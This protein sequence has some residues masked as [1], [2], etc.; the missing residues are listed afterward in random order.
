[1]QKS[2]CDMFLQTLF[3]GQDFNIF[4]RW[5]DAW[6]DGALCVRR[7]PLIDH[8]PLQG[9]SSWLCKN[10]FHVRLVFRGFNYSIKYN[11]YKWCLLVAKGIT[12]LNAGRA[13]PIFGTRGRPSSLTC[14]TFLLVFTTW[15]S[16]M[17]GLPRIKLISLELW[18]YTSNISLWKRT[19]SGFYMI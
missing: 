16:R 17:L 15:P 9:P 4:L 12:K 6:R 5:V 13:T 1:M 8:H 19:F 11:I 7:V 14:L 2:L 18:P 3:L 10:N